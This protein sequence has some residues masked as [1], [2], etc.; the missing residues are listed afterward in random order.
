MKRALLLCL[1]AL[2]LFA[3]EEKPPAAPAAP[4]IHRWTDKQGVVHYTDDP[5]SIPADAKA[6]Q[7]KGAEIKVVAAVKVDAGPTTLGSE[8]QW[9]ARFAE[10]NKRIAE[11]EAEIEKDLPH[12]GDAET[13]W[14]LEEA[15]AGDTTFENALRRI[16]VNRAELKRQQAALEELRKNAD[17]ANVP[18]E[19]RTPEK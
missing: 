10:S 2:P 18:A 12:V 17:L 11:L 8:R 19:W 9:R 14:V 3:C 7:T 5:E 4:T 1:A 6:E 16:K 15:N 13:N